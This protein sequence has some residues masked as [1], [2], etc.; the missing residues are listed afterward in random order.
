MRVYHEIEYSLKTS[1]GLLELVTA[2]I[3][4]TVDKVI[5]FADADSADLGGLVIAVTSC[6][7]YGPD[8]GT[9]V[10]SGGGTVVASAGAG[11]SVAAVSYRT[12]YDLWRLPASRS[13]WKRLRPSGLS[14]W[15]RCWGASI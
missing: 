12:R 11:F 15:S 9:L 2:D 13:C 8:L 6:V 14:R 7:W 4:E 1:L 10:P 3:E 5:G